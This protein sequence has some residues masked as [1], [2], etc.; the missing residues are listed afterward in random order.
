MPKPAPAPGEPLVPNAPQTWQAVTVADVER[1]LVFDRLP[2]DGGV[3]TPIAEAGMYPEQEVADQ[4]G[5]LADVLVAWLPGHVSDP[6][7]RTRNLLFVTAVVDV[8]QMP[9]EPYLPEIVYGEIRQRLSSS[10]LLKVLYWI[11]VHPDQGSIPSV[12]EFRSLGLRQVSPDT[13]ELRNRA[14]IYGVKLL[15]RL[16]GHIR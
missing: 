7:Q 1:D 9:M 10:D 4:I 5:A 13:E 14:A 6:V 11:A 2:P 15:G 16:T 12:E 3:V 8:A